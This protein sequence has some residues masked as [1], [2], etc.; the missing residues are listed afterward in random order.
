MPMG[1]AILSLTLVKGQQ[2]IDRQVILCSAGR[3]DRMLL[4]YATWWEAT[5]KETSQGLKTQQCQS[6]GTAGD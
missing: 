6:G 2:W 1:N 5:S 3:H 4:A